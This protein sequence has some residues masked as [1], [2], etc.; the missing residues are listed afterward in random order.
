MT[1]F[2]CCA[3]AAAISSLQVQSW[4]SQ[5]TCAAIVINNASLLSNICINHHV[6]P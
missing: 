6:L 2:I 4:P 3:F 1:Y 5:L